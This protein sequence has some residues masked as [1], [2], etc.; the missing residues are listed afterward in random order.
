MNFGCLAEEFEHCSAEVRNVVGR[1]AD[2]ISTISDGELDTL[3]RMI[4]VVAL[5]Q[6]QAGASIVN[7]MG[8]SKAGVY[9]HLANWR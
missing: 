8:S 5:G 3:M 1:G 4:S 2:M 9:L 6:S 7:T